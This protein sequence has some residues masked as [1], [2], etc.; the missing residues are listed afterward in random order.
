MAVLRVLFRAELRHRWRSWL[1]LSLLVALVSGL[2][3]AGVVA[4]RRT[5]TAFPR[6]EATYGYDAFIYSVKPL[7]GLAR[8]PD[9]AATIQV[10]SVGSGDPYCDCSHPIDSNE[11]GILE[12]PPRNLTH[13]VKLVSGRMPDQSDPD[14]VL[15]SYP[16]A[17]DDGVH[18]GT[19]IHVHLAAVSQLDQVLADADFTPTGPRVALRVVGIETAEQEFPTTYSPGYDV[20]T[21]EAFDHSFDPRSV[22]H[23]TYLVRLRHGA[24]DLPAFE[25]QAGGLGAQGGADLDT[26]AS[27]VTSSIHPQAVGWWLLSGLVGLV[28]LIV[29]GQAL[30]RQATVES[31]TF[32]ALSALGVSRRHLVMAGMART[33]AIGVVGLVGGTLLAYLLS[34]LTPVGEARLADP[35]PGF[36]FDAAILLLGL[37]IGILVVLALGL[38]PS[39]RA[40]RIDRVSVATRTARPSRTVALLTGA[41]ASPSALIGVRHAL[42]RGRGRNSVP[43]GSALAGSILAVTAVC[44]TFVFGASLTHLTTTPALYGQPFDVWFG[45]NNTGTEA[46][47]ATLLAGIQHQGAVTDITAGISNDVSI[48]GRTVNA[49]GGQPVRGHLLLT[50][51]EGRLP[52]TGDEVSLGP[53]TMRE[54]GAHIGSRVRVTVPLSDGGSRTSSFRVVGTTSFPPDFGTGG[55]GAGAIFS[56]AGLAGTSCP[57]GRGQEAC[58]VRTVF[59]SEGAFLVRTA[60][61]P[62]GQAALT[63]LARAFPDEVNQPLAPTDL[64]NFGEAVNFPLILGL[65]LIVFGVATLLHVLVVSVTRRR[66]EIGLLKALG[67]VRRQVAASVAWQTTTVALVGIVVGVPVGVA[68]GRL[69]WD[70][71]AGNLG[72]LP[73]PVVPG[74]VIAAVVAG[75]LLVANLLAIGPAVVA[76]RSSPADLLRSE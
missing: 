20:F 14:Q 16:L 76:S 4:A 75:T 44:A 13:V 53:T 40:A 33:L 39:V 63:T 42:E 5:A 29:V 61:G 37:L 26:E 30:A 43:V 64:V 1:L 54:A 7:P 46:Q 10:P 70:A 8:L 27:A 38:W 21:T 12:V 35:D 15:A 47:A 72:V 67:L 62:S 23:E 22:H 51:T 6:Y 32:T 73:V 36:T 56:F 66:R 19:V 50:T 74:L 65:V 9:V 28:G 11:F 69:V 48:D 71:F 49:L 55:L 25:T 24:H 2:V 18:L 57:P 52:R 60:P 17:Q 34:P 41:G 59:A 3:L 31:D 68:V 58:V 45:V